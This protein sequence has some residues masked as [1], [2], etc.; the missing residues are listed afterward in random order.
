MSSCCVSSVCWLCG[1][2]AS[3][4]CARL[5]CPAGSPPT[6]PGTLPLPAAPR[7]ARPRHATPRTADRN[8][9]RH[10]GHLSLFYSLSLSLP[11]SLSISGHLSLFSFHSFHSVVCLSCFFSSSEYEDIALQKRLIVLIVS[12]PSSKLK[13]KTLRSNKSVDYSLSEK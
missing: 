9:A 12:E 13:K 11:L 5:P 6:P 4:A 2:A 1:R 3:S 10:S 7:Q 8:S